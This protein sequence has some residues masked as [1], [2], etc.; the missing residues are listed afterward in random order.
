MDGFSTR[1]KIMRAVE[2]KLVQY[3]QPYHQPETPS[4]LNEKYNL[5]RRV[6]LGFNPD[7][8][9]Y[10]CLGGMWMARKSVKIHGASDTIS[11]AVVAN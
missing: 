7:L 4:F 8:M 5:I 10:E 3:I 1:T 11:G 2:E 9:K 6:Y